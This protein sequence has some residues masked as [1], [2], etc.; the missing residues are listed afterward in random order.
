MV[1]I[2]MPSRK[3]R[4]A[5]VGAWQSRSAAP[6]EKVSRRTGCRVG[7]IC[8]TKHGARESIWTVQVGHTV[9]IGTSGFVSASPPPP[10]NPRRACFSRPGGGRAGSASDAHAIDTRAAFRPEVFDL[11]HAIATIS[12]L[13]AELRPLRGQHRIVGIAL[14]GRRIQ[15]VPIR[16][17]R[18]AHRP[19]S[20][21][22][23]RGWGHPL[24]SFSPLSSGG[25]DQERLPFAL[26]EAIAETLFGC[27][28]LSWR[29]LGRIIETFIQEE[30][31]GSDILIAVT[32]RQRSKTE[33]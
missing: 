30:Q 24:A 32:L 4:L 16:P 10:G 2:L 13:P 27:L 21:R 1:V 17:D 22:S 18:A 25:G 14:G 15:R 19:S 9:K 7:H 5:G 6:R 12:P 33:S 28:Q 20:V 3:R 26:N 8:Q 23:T 29:Y 31:T 11:D